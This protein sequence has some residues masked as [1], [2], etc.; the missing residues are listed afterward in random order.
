MSSETSRFVESREQAIRHHAKL[1]EQ[2]ASAPT[3]GRFYQCLLDHKVWTTRRELSIELS[4]SKG[5]VSKAINA[6]RL[7]PEVL[8]VFGPARRVSF[9]VTGALSELVAVVGV[10]KIIARAEQLGERPDLTVTQVLDCLVRGV[11]PNRE[12][13]AFELSVGR[14]GRYIRIDSPDIL[15]MISRLHE[16]ETALN[17]A[18]EM[19]SYKRRRPRG[20]SALS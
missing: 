20:F 3:Y 11:T 9:R 16:L 4:I 12:P 2:K 14:G 13:R 18:M 17:L 19:A 15:K 8:Q 6:A 10:E 1:R 5:H 7:P